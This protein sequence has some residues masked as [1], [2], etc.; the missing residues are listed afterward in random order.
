MLLQQ[1]ANRQVKVQFIAL[2]IRIGALTIPRMK[3]AEER[4]REK[5]REL[6][7]TYGLEEVARRAD[8]ASPG[9]LRQIL[10]GV[11]GPERA[12][13]TRS[14]RHVGTDMARAIEAGFQLERGW[15]DSDADTAETVSTA[16]WRQ[17]AELLARHCDQIAQPVTH[18]AFLLLVDAAADSLPDQASER[19]AAAVFKRL[20]P[21]IEHGAR[22]A[23]ASK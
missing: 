4:R 22:T 21:L 16:R 8:N 18:A 10:S 19:D 23:S 20:W 5:L 6:V 7:E 2:A 11:L 13:G 14:P 1:L 12:D 9:Y 3:T 17:A 15:M